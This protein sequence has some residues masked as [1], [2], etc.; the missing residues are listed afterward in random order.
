M[1]TRSTTA[2]QTLGPDRRKAQS[3]K[4]PPTE[5]PAGQVEPTA[6]PCSPARPQDGERGAGEPG[7]DEA[8]RSGGR[9]TGRSRR[10]V[11]RRLVTAPAPSASEAGADQA[12]GEPTTDALVRIRTHLA[13]SIGTEAFERYFVQQARLEV[14]DGQLRVH[15]ASGFIA[16]VIDRRF[17]PQLREAAG[18]LASAGAETGDRVRVLIDA[19]AAGAAAANERATLDALRPPSAPDTPK[20]NGQT[21]E[22]DEPARAASRHHRAARPGQPRGGAHTPGAQAGVAR[23]HRL[24]RF[25]VGESNKLAF[26]AALSAADPGRG[27]PFQSLFIHGPC[28]T[29]KTHLLQ[30][31]ASAFRKN[32][33]GPAASP[34]RHPRAQARAS[35][36]SGVRYM[37]GEAFTN[38]FVTAVREGKMD[39]FREQFQGVELF[40]IDDVHFV[41]N[42][43]QTQQE[44]QHLFDRLVSAG[45]RVVIAS[46]APPQQI[47]KL[48]RTLGSRFA[49]GMVVRIDPP[50]AVLQRTLVERFAQ[51]RNLPL[52]PEATALIAQRAGRLG[53]SVGG[54]SVRD[55]EGMLTQVD[56]VYRLLPELCVEPGRIGPGLIRRALG[57][58]ANDEGSRPGGSASGAT[59]RRPVTLETIL[60]EVSRELRVEREE[61][62]GRGRHKRVVMTRALVTLLSR[63]MT[64]ASF[65]EI[66]RVLGRPNH[67]TVITALR[68]IEGQVAN[69]EIV[70]LGLEADGLT[71]GELASK[72]ESVLGQSR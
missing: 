11:A 24:E 14:I 44:L 20:G 65:P 41:S 38:A 58:G 3:L 23:Q 36:G 33:S 67:S 8:R 47:E 40:C 25:V 57:L 1:S 16:A 49:S 26:S 68:R 42:K 39:A 15:A 22:D 70:G 31:V 6:P 28:G 60:S 19:N 18:E 43:Q 27:L 9:A 53:A 54:A 69:G 72:L 10:V 34:G 61:V 12:S 21:G 30:G 66:A 7:R 13:A 32:A 59:P 52:T 71:I 63:R 46:D 45:A 37:T 5:E 56:A 62:M 2:S 17:G 55:I 64:T 48:S 29:G 50:D 51:E 35:S 4:R